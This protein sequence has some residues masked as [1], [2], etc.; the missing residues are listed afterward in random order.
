MLCINRFA[1]WDTLVV[2]IC[3]ECSDRLLH[4]VCGKRARNNEFDDLSLSLYFHSIMIV[5]E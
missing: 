4:S 1:I 2:G 5:I 3:D